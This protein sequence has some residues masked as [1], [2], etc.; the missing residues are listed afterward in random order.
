MPTLTNSR[1]HLDQVL[2]KMDQQD[3]SI[4]NYSTLEKVAHALHMAEMWQHAKKHYDALALMPPTEELCSCVQDTTHNG[5]TQE[6]NLLALKIKYPG[7]TS[8]EFG[9]A[10]PLPRIKGN[11]NIKAYRIAYDLS[12]QKVMAPPV[13]RDFIFEGEEEEVVGRVAEQ[14]VD[15]DQGNE[16]GLDSE[17]GWEYWK[18]GFKGMSEVG[19]YEFAVFMFCKL[20]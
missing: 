5:I 13:P 6:L 11:N 17:E 7:I 3:F 19:N 9:A 2:R 1:R 8:G 18:S 16:M 12:S 14:L 15:G 4:T 10:A 20:N